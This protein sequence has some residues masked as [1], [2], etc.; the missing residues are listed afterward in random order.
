[1]DIFLQSS[2]KMLSYCECLEQPITAS[3][4]TEIDIGMDNSVATDYL[5]QNKFAN[6][7]RTQ[8]QAERM[9]WNKIAIQSVY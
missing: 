5:G 8:C 4:L 6:I 2:W 3:V 1:M 7:T 9:R